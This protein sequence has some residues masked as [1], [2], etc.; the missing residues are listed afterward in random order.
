MVESKGDQ[1]PRNL[2]FNYLHAIPNNVLNKMRVLDFG[3]GPGNLIPHIDKKP[4]QLIGVDRSEGSLK[5]ACSIAVL[6]HAAI[7]PRRNN[8]GWIEINSCTAKNIFP[9]EI[10]SQIWIRVLS[11]IQRRD[12]GLVHNRRKGNVISFLQLQVLL[13]HGRRF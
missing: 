2:L 13:R 11:S 6:S 4:A 7:Y 10:V 3:C 12:L 8:V 5:I 1:S 9:L